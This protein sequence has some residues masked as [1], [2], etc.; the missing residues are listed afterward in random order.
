MK[1]RVRIEY[2][3]DDTEAW[4]VHTACASGEHEVGVLGRLLAE[5][6]PP[7]LPDGADIED[8]VADLLIK[9][10]CEVADPWYILATARRHWDRQVPFADVVQLHVDL[11]RLTDRADV[12][13]FLRALGVVAQR[14]GQTRS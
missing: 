6:V 1:L 11:D 7:V 3:Q 12:Q 8:V 4:G 9:A 13:T 5:C 10:S 14:T 2:A